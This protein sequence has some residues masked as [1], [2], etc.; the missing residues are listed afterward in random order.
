VDDNLAAGYRAAAAEE[1]GDAA[2]A[3]LRA[4]VTLTPPVNHFPVPVPMDGK[5]WIIPVDTTAHDFVR[6][7]PEQS[8]GFELAAQRL[9]AARAAGVQ[10]TQ[11]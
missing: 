2:A 10:T 9:R 4:E 5:W 8:V 7:A 3:G 6:A 1:L 11:A